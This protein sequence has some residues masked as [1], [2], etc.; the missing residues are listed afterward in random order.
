MSRPLGAFRLQGT[1]PLYGAGPKT[2]NP[3]GASGSTSLLCL[4]YR[5]APRH[6]V[7]WKPKSK[8]IRAGE[9]NHERE[10]SESDEGRQQLF[11]SHVFYSG[12]D[13]VFGLCFDSY[14]RKAGSIPTAPEG[15]DQQNTADQAL[16]LDGR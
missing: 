10:Y 1:C 2:K 16:T 8:R 13:H 7:G 4:T 3:L 11:C 15:F 12:R 5:I 6:L 9:A 14:R